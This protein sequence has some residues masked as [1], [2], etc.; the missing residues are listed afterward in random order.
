[1]TSRGPAE[2]LPASEQLAELALA[3]RLYHVHDVRQRDIAERLGTSQARVSRLLQQAADSGIVRTS[4]IVPE[5]IAPELEE[6]LEEAYGIQEVHV[7]DVSGQPDLAAALGR[8]AARYLAE[9]SFAG[10]TVGFTSWSRTLQE[11]ARALPELTRTGVTHVVEL[12]GDLG[13]PQLQHDATRSTQE[14]ARAL[15]AEPVFLRTPGVASS[16]SSRTLQLADPY[17][18]AALARL[19]SLDVAFVGVGPAGVHSWLAA[20]DNYFTA[21]QLAQAREA[22]A[23][24]QL[25]QRFVDAKGQ[26]VETGLDDLVVGA[27]LDQL[28]SA[29][30]RVVVA[31]GSDKHA[32]LEAAA[33]G[34]WIDVLV[35]DL[36]AAHYLLDRATPLPHSLDAV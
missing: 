14:M 29:Q 20:G 35:V 7:V 19:D 3:A 12:L 33:C 6:A 21:E 24:A 2:G 1:M 13:A 25:I 18:A 30:R 17:V 11:M 5:G 16:P 36:Q 10:G 9:A 32:A 8:A 26:P 28:R 27:T 4:V 31:G 34:G 22:G 15:G 23:V